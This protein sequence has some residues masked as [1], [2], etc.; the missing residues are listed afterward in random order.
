MTKGGSPVEFS[1]R[2]DGWI[3]YEDDDWP[4]TITLLAGV[5]DGA[6]RLLGLQLIP[7]QDRTDSELVV[8]AEALR[9]LPLQRL[10]RG[11]I[12]MKRLDFGQAFNEMQRTAPRDPDHFGNVARVYRH[13]RETAREGGPRAAIAQ[14]WR[15]SEKTVD[16]WIREARQRGDL[17][18][19][20]STHTTTEEDQ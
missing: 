10:T 7:R 9:R 3:D 4:W 17:E 16:R 1:L 12:A 13:A 20:K 15:V 8:T 6:P 2:A 19:W 14:L 11:A 18:P 5:V